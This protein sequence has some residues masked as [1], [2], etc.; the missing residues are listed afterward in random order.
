MPWIPELFSAP[1]L[2]RLEEKWQRERLDTVPYYD[3]LMSEEHAAL[4]GSFAGEP[5][6]H[7]PLHGR[8]RGAREL[9]AYVSELNAW[10]AQHNMSFEPVDDVV[11]ETR[12]FDEVILHLEGRA[13]RVDVALTDDSGRPG[14]VPTDRRVP[15]QLAS[16]ARRP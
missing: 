13:G 15:S 9:E 5:V 14:R 10:L 16:L 2:A 3:G 7:D 11:T 4:I 8:V 6:L 1:V 12:A